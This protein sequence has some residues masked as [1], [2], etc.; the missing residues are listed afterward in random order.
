MSGKGAAPTKLASQRRRRTPSPGFRQLPY[1]GRIGE[2]PSWPLDTPSSMELTQWQKLWTLPQA[3][4]WEQMRC[5]D[6]VALYVRAYCE[7]LLDA[8]PKMLNEVRQLD[9]KLGL[10]PRSMLDLRWEIEVPEE[11]SEESSVEVLADRSFVP[12][13]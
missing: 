8:N 1:E 6:T 13:S 11:E 5:E 2:P 4:V 3:T 10:S 9:S 7:A 12:N